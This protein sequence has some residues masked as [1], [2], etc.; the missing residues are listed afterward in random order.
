VFLVQQP[1]RVWHAV[2]WAPAGQ[3]PFP[4]PPRIPG[5]VTVAKTCAQPFR[6]QTSGDG[7]SVEVSQKYHLDPGVG[8][9]ESLTEALASNHAVISEV[10]DFYSRSA[11]CP[12]RRDSFSFLYLDMPNLLQFAHVCDY[13]RCAGPMT[14]N[15][16]VSGFGT[17]TAGLE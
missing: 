5:L 11:Q 16:R 10:P 1:V 14:A 4:Q 17:V 6:G 3:H 13:T 9:H 12:C 2:G 8:L 7:G 15:D